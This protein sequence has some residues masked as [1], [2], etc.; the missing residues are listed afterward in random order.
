MASTPHPHRPD[1]ARPVPVST[2]RFQFR[3]EFTF[4]DAQ[5]L[6]EYVKDLGVGAVYF[7]PY[8]RA[9]PGSSHGYDVVNH[10]VINPEL[11][12]EDAFKALAEKVHD[13]DMLVIADIVPNHVSVADPENLNPYW[14]D[15]LKNGQQSKYR[16]WFDVEWGF[17]GTDGKVILPVLGGEL[18]ELLQKGEVR[19]DEEGGETVVRYWSHVFPVKPGTEGLK[20][21]VAKLLEAQNYKLVFWRSVLTGT[22]NY[23]R[24]F[25]VTTLAGIRVEDQSVFDETHK[26]YKEQIAKGLLDGL[27]VDHPDGLANPGEY[28]E[29]LYDASQGS[30]VVIEKILEEG[31]QLPKDWKC[32][33]TS[34]YDAL[35]RLVGVLVKKNSENQLTQV[36]GDFT[37]MKQNFKEV[38]RESK[39]FILRESLK[40]EVERLVS[41]LLLVR[42]ND[43]SGSKFERED[44]K[45]ALIEFLTAFDVY[46]AYIQPG[47]QVPME[48]QAH[49][50]HA[51]KA[52]KHTLPDKSGV[53]DFIAHVA[54][55]ATSSYPPTVEFLNRFQQTCGP[56][57]AKGVE[58]TAFYR[59]NR[60]I[61]L[62]EVGGDPGN[63]GKTSEEFHEACVHMQKEWPL[64]MTTLSTHDTKRSEDVRAR[65][66]V[67]SEIPDEWSKA[68]HNWSRVVREKLGNS[69]FD[70]NTEYF[71]WQTLVGAFPISEE[72]LLA[73][74]NKAVREAKVHLTHT[75][76]NDDYINALT[77]FV[78]AA[79][80]DKDVMDSVKAF[81]ASIKP[82]ARR[83]MLTQKTLCL[84]MPG[85]PDVY[86]GNEIEDFSLVDPDNRRPVDYERRRNLLRKVKSEGVSKDF[87]SVDADEAKMHL[88]STLLHLRQKHFRSFI[89]EDSLSSYS[90]L[91][92]RGRKKDHAI[93]YVRGGNV[94]VVVGRFWVDIVAD[95]WFDTSV[96]LPEGTWRSVLRFKDAPELTFSGGEVKL[97][98]LLSQWGVG[99]FV[100]Q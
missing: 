66:A 89:G 60:L 53:F 99:V 21:D 63:F 4:N 52:C 17:P 5:P 77:T 65:L 80:S 23:R 25:D 51:V 71:F 75:D 59:Y 74:L 79:L 35:I 11:G 58:D 67:L 46:R 87:D 88:T 50:D 49:I 9:T 48:S 97:W 92:I 6:I 33:G 13:N 15:L 86:Q 73:Y 2:Y 24:F 16:D 70:K 98:N 68:V 95:G 76:P 29:R 93:A 32:A 78:K 62:S 64:T 40:A 83:N 72:R 96:E 41:L 47:K 37:G 38:V 7:S 100:K 36:Y 28:V 82:Y 69:A 22:L 54:T 19:V 61:A 94:L 39:L 90:P 85:V 55:N 45:E 30:W 8:L 1:P 44:I 3:K 57:M 27:R 56:V 26:V 10:S 81:V 34:G 42:D 14:W 31:E 18:H 12:G 91:E 43:W 20:N 84:T